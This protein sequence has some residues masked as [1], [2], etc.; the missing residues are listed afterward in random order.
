MNRLLAQLLID[1]LHK[2]QER[3]SANQGGPVAV[4]PGPWRT[5][6]GATA[7]ATVT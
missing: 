7:R 4:P 1:N 2:A 6:C 3:M 5:R